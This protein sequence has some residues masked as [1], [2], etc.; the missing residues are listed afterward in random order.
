MKPYFLSSVLRCGLVLLLSF[1]GA[2]S[3]GGIKNVAEPKVVAGSVSPLQSRL[4]V[5]RAKVLFKEQ[6]AGSLPQVSF[7]LQLAFKKGGDFEGDYHLQ[8][9]LQENV[10]GRI[11][12]LGEADAETVSLQNG[13]IK[14]DPLMFR[15][16]K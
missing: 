13:K 10:N 9:F 15:L 7:A 8:A 1:T 16:V 3:D 4:Q 12:R 5:K 2:C 6:K 11:S 14:I